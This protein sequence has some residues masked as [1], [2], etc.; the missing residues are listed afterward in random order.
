MLVQ[1]SVLPS[2][3]QFVVVIRG[4]CIVGIVGA[5]AGGSCTGGCGRSAPD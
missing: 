5:C 4:A 1:L 2:H 3:V